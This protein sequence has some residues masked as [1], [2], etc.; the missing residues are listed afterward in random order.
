MDGNDGLLWLALWS[1]R[2]RDPPEAAEPCALMRG[3]GLEDMSVPTPGAA[4]DE[5]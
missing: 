2:A 1:L 5:M 3:G 4:R